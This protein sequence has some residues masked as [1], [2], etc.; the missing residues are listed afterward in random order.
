ML[1]FAFLSFAWFDTHRRAT[2]PS[3]AE[4]RAGGLGKQMISGALNAIADSSCVDEIHAAQLW[5]QLTIC[6]QETARPTIHR[7]SRSS[8][9]W[10]QNFE[11]SLADIAA[12][13]IHGVRA[14]SHTAK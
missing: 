1:P 7:Q 13:V 8:R 5:L 10:G 3:P 2:A 14:P 12:A 9:R 6:S 4:S 11:V